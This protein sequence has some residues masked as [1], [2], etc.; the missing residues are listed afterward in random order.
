[1]AI[2]RKS[3][4][5]YGL[6]EIYYTDIQDPEHQNHFTLAQYANPA[7][8]CY[9]INGEACLFSSTPVE[10]PFLQLS[11]RAELHHNGCC[12]QC[13]Q[14]SNVYGI[15]PCSL[16]FDQAR[17]KYCFG[18]TKGPCSTFNSTTVL[19]PIHSYG[20]CLECCKSFNDGCCVCEECCGSTNSYI[21]HGTT[22]YEC[23]YYSAHGSRKVHQKAQKAN[24]CSACFTLWNKLLKFKR[25]VVKETLTDEYG[26]VTARTR[27]STVDPPHVTYR[28]G[29]T[30]DSM[31]TTTP[32]SYNSSIPV[33]G[34]L[35]IQVTRNFIHPWYLAPIRQCLICRTIYHETIKGVSDNFDLC[36]SC[37]HYWVRNHEKATRKY[38]LEPS[39]ALSYPALDLDDLLESYDIPGG[40]F[41][42]VFLWAR[43]STPGCGPAV[44]CYSYDFLLKF[45]SKRK[46]ENGK[47]VLAGSGRTYIVPDHYFKAGQSDSTLVSYSGYK[48]YPNWNDL[49][50][51][52]N[53]VLD[54]RPQVTS[55]ILINR[56]DDLSTSPFHLRIAL[57]QFHYPKRTFIVVRS[58]TRN[59]NRSG[60]CAVSELLDLLDSLADFSKIS[61]DAGL[62]LTSCYQETKVTNKETSKHRTDEKNNPVIE[63]YSS[64]PSTQGGSQ[65]LTKS[66]SFSIPDV[67]D[68]EGLEDITMT[69]QNQSEFNYPRLL[70][71]N[72]GF[73]EANYVDVVDRK[74]GEKIFKDGD[75]VQ[76]LTFASTAES[77]K[78]KEEKSKK[79]R[80]K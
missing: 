1:M 26:N 50:R 44:A 2:N 63:L 49:A 56:M 74:S 75:V 16:H 10:D 59:P 71:L 35:T 30:I 60:T 39:R 14:S 55:N 19:Q 52:I 70:T 18:S 42:I 37:V 58:L 12:L 9:G 51:D 20:M 7:N 57:E 46:V 43:N 48:Q 73:I 31:N 32:Q 38:S 76:A 77:R 65:P 68:E 21:C 11:N 67:M 40:S 41:K 15:C 66:G 64:Q 34:I 78:P 25:K 8:Y 62:C 33:P 4:A 13:C 53:R 79:R 22:L 36:N 3:I 80:M 5:D 69:V 27:T 23:V 61:T 29:K 28:E 24:V 45:K 72:T 17:A 54:C 6:L 47:K